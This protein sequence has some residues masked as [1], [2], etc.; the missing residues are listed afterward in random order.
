MKS[1]QAFN[2]QKDFE[3]EDSWYSQGEIMNA[4][5]FECNHWS[6]TFQTRS[7]FMKHRKEEHFKHVSIFEGELNGCTSAANITNVSKIGKSE[8]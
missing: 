2:S 7:A 3:D 1:M 4:K 8:I 5:T 6:K